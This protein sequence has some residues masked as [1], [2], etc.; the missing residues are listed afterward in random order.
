[1]ELQGFIDELREQLLAAA[2][3]GGEQSRAAAERMTASIDSTARLV[4]LDAISAAA[5]EITVDLAPGSVE[6]RLRGRDPEFAVTLPAEPAAFPTQAP[7][8]AETD[9]S[10]TARI[11]LRLSE[12]LKLRVESAASRQALSVN[13]WMVRAIASAAD[14]SPTAAPTSPSMGQ[15]FTGWVR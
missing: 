7:R 15:S 5:E 9:D 11:T 4:L 6:V 1:M 12:T 3:H 14:G 10:G 8:Q 13:A 2:E